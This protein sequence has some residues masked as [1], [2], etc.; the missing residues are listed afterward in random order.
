MF[1]RG[2]IA[3]LALRLRTAARALLGHSL[4]GAPRVP[5]VLSLCVA[6][7]Q[8]M[9]QS[10]GRPIRVTLTAESC[11]VRLT[12][13]RGGVFMLTMIGAAD[14]TTWVVGYNLASCR[15]S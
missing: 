7:L 15:N 9:R 10:L 14:V 13:G 11:Y 4:V 8:S 5:L 2:A 6:V 1:A 3:P 12:A